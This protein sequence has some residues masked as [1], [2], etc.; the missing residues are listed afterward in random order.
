MPQKKSIFSDSFRTAQLLDV[1]VGA[2]RPRPPSAVS[3]LRLP[4]RPPAALISSTAS[5]WPLNIGCE[6]AAGPVKNV[7]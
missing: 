5:C 3:I 1:R 6:D 4:S 7:M 2:R